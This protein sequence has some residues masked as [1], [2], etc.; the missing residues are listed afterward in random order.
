MSSAATRWV[1]DANVLLRYLLRDDERLAGKARRAFQA[2]EDGQIEAVLEP[3]TLAEAVFVMGSVYQVPRGEISEALLSLLQADGVVMAQKARYLAALRLFGG[4]LAHFG[5]ACACA[6][7]LE[8]CEGR[9]LS[10]DRKLSAVPGIQ[11]RE[12]PE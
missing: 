8:E 5:D 1:L 7:A 2:V 9:L 6:A 4:P 3:V 10:F 12:T 11:R